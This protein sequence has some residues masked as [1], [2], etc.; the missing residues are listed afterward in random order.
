MVVRRSW[1]VKK[2]DEHWAPS[3]S[4]SPM[5][6]LRA[7]REISPPQASAD[8]HVSPGPRQRACREPASLAAS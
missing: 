2:K 3:R 6:A 7:W 4:L 5:L 1:D 8:A